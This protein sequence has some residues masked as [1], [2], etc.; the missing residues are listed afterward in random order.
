LS[1][2]NSDPAVRRSAAIWVSI[3]GDLPSRVTAIPI[4][5]AAAKMDESVDAFNAF[6]GIGRCVKTL[7]VGLTDKASA[8]DA[9]RGFQQFDREYLKTYLREYDDRFKQ[10]SGRDLRPIFQSAADGGIKPEHR[11]FARTVLNWLGKGQQ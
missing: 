6:L 3:Y 10:I 7:A 8:D 2:N 11:Q 1:L 5:V 4:L 9:F